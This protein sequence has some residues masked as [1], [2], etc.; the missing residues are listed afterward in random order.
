M[1]RLKLPVLTLASSLGLFACDDDVGVAPDAGSGGDATIGEETGSGGEDTGTTGQDTGTDQQA[2]TIAFEARVGDVLF[3]CAETYS[4]LGSSGVDAQFHEFRAYV[5]DVRLIDEAGNQVPVALEQDGVWQ[6][7][8]LVLLDFE[9]D[10]GTCTNGTSQTN[11]VVRGTVPAGRQ[12]EGVVFKLGVPESLNHTNVATSPSPLNLA[13]MGW[14]W[15]MGR[16]FVRMDVTMPLPDGQVGPPGRFPF[17]LGST[18]CTGN[19]AA[20]E[21]V[22]CQRENRPEITLDG[23]DPDR[24]KIVI[25]YAALVADVALDADQGEDAGCISDPD[26]PECADLFAKLGLDVNTGQPAGTQSV[27]SVEAGSSGSGGNGSGSGG[28]GSTG[29]SGDYAWELPPGFPVPAVPEDNPMSEIKVELG[30]RL[31][32]DKRLSGNGTQSCATCHQQA[33]AFTDGHAQGVGS[34]GEVHPRGPMSLANVAYA[35]ALNWANP[36]VTS[37]EQQAE[38]PMFGE[39]PIEL[40]LTGHEDD[41]IIMIS[42]ADYY[43]DAFPQAFPGEADPY[44]IA[45]IIRAIAS[46]ERTLISGNSPYDRYANQGIEGAISESAKRGEALFFGEQLDCFHC[47]GGFNFSDS[48]NHQGTVFTE[49]SFHNTGLYNLDPT[50]AYPPDNQGLYEFTGDIYDMGKF[51]AP[52]LRNIAVTAPYMHDGSVATLEEAIDHYRL[53]GRTVSEGPYRGVG[54]RNVAKSEFVHG[55]TLT[56]Q[57]RA[58][59]LAFLESLTDET[60]LTDPRFSNPWE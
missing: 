19:P 45:N 20:D 17:H 57:E 25:D 33:L 28:N 21:P 59:I 1:H 39:D 52:T 60:F 40:G 41:L 16:K 29:T 22:T 12:Y 48:V 49:V 2:V 38:G 30:R 9:D 24:A 53:G 23:F 54:S 42:N 51:K 35:S 8:N 46:F 37:L 5:H 58:D 13:A 43:K 50:G 31:F 14:S 15:T 27:F 36:L 11:A 18:L 56:E 10:T 44:T 7:E 55:F 4:G 3:D 34:T 32:Y 26:D 6:H 47:H